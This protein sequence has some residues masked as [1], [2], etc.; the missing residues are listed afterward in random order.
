MEKKELTHY[1]DGQLFINR[2]LSWLGF[3]NRVL[4]E[5]KDSTNPL[6]EKIKFL[7]IT[8]SNMDEFFMIR[9]ASLKDMVNANYTKK[10][11]AGLT[12]EEQLNLIS[13]KTHQLVRDQYGVYN[14]FLS[15]LYKKGI[16]DC[17]RLGKMTA[18]IERLDS[19]K[20]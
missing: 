12:P 5:T 10:D 1:E 16:I 18:L 9:V 19:C 15:Q 6:F 11:M 2:E 13:N 8:A 4:L 17:T 7:S 20:R 14:K 3:N